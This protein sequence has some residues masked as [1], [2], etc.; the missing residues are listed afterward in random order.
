[1]IHE[2]YRAKCET[3]GLSKLVAFFD[4]GLD[5]IRYKARHLQAPFRTK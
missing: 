1:V 5:L 3:G 2:S 4:L